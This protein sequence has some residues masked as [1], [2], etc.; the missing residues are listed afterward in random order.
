MFPLSTRAKEAIKTSLAMVIAYWIAMSMG[1]DKP[2][3]AGFTVV[4]IN[5]LSAGVSL[6]RGITRTLGTLVGAVAGLAIM[7]LFPQ[8]RWWLMICLSLY[9]GFCTYMLTGKNQSYFWFLA[10]FTCLII[11]GVNSPPESQSAFQVAVL[12]TQE[13]AMGALVYTL[14]AVFLWPRSSV[15]EFNK[16]SCKLWATQIRLYDAYRDLMSGKGAA[17]DSRP[18]RL[19]EIQQQA[20][21]GQLLNAAETDSYEVWQVHHQWRRF[22]HQS[23]ALMET[24][25]RWRQ[26]FAEIQPLN[27][28]RLLPNL[29]AVSAELNLRFEQIARML[30]D[31]APTRTAQAIT[32]AV[33]KAE[34]RSLTRFEEAAVIVTRAQ[35]EN[36]ERL[37][38]SLFDCVADIRGYTQQ[39]PAP[40]A[41]LSRR[42][43]LALDPDRFRAVVRVVVTLWIAFF[44]WVYVDPLGHSAYVMMA[45]IF[46]LIIAMVPQASTLLLFLSW[47]GGIAF[48][49]VL[50]IFVMPHLSGFAELAVL[51]FAAVFIMHYLLGKPQQTVARMFTMASFLILI[52]IDNQQS[53][54]FS[55]YANNV[56]WIMLSLALAVATAYIPTSPRP[57]KVFLRLLRRFFRQAEF[58]VSGLAPDGQRPKG[59]IG[60]W[61]SVLY[62]NDLLELPGK[63]AAYGKQIDYRTFPDNTPEQVQALVASLYAV[64]Y[65]IKD[66]VEA[67]AYP[68]TELV[69]K[70]LLDDLRAWHQVIDARLQLRAEDPTQFIEP[71]GDVRGRL[72]ARLGGLEASIAEMFAQSGKGELSTA[73]Y[74]NLYRLLGSY[75]GLSE[76]AI[77]YAQL[78]EG[79][80]WAEWQEARF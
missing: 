19:Q 24:L 21:V 45:G 54:S 73:D 47:G 38:R 30:A 35:L 36:L 71:I 18:L 69:K 9:V 57:E 22:H 48:A 67:H 10:S 11:I 5:V 3:W 55:Q 60:R 49:G 56:V 1:W 64:A 59:I 2:Y 63:L 41:E 32:L 15:G 26:S 17:K 44:L 12:R 13:T 52:G 34:M 28:T 74:K 14:V 31:E 79:I 77:G 68:Q 40:A 46:A 62:Q 20:L 53:Y 4:T 72:A 7:G 51:I 37:S 65:R 8:E 43:G 23:T 80:K 76:A 50:Y 75:R 27:L 70:R 66:L 16:A 39:A 6:T 42:R 25:E 58:Q 33:D 78:A 61:K 29:D